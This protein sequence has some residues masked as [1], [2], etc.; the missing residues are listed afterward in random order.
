MK[1][2]QGLDGVTFL[3]V[4]PAIQAGLPP[5]DFFYGNF[6]VDV[7][8]E[9][10]RPTRASAAGVIR[11]GH[12]R[13][14]STMILR[15]GDDL[16]SFSEAGIHRRLVEPEIAALAGKP[17]QSRRLTGPHVLLATGRSHRIY[18]H[19]L[20]DHLPKLFLLEAAGFD[21]S[22]LRFLWPASARRFAMRMLYEIGISDASLVHYD[23]EKDIL[24]IDELLV[25]TLIRMGKLA[26]PVLRDVARFLSD[27][28]GPS[29]GVHEVG[30]RLFV[31]RGN[32]GPRPL[33]NRSAIEAL[34]KSHG[35]HIVSPET[36]SFGEQVHMF[37]RATRIV[38]EYGSALHNSI[39]SKR[40][41]VVCAL[42]GDRFVP[43][44][45]QSSIGQC[46]EQPTGYV[47]GAE[48]PGEAKTW[49]VDEG[50]VMEALRFMN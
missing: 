41:T 33:A 16:A 29:S 18:G 36:M 28:I 5:P 45:L 25:P 14:Q 21:L 31:A 43:G 39:F 35:Y 17:T 3:K 4:A 11:T 34:A 9:Y 12:V 46:L 15:V 49:S 8:A 27:R 38:G 37:R 30:E 40:G 42:R 44:F 50:D 26:G 23:D 22:T 6:P 13:L 7:A 32:G 2:L 24:E 47:F 19:W 48:V 10:A 1:R 20:I